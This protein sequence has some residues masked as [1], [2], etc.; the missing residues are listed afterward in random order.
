MILWLPGCFYKECWL[1][2]KDDIMATLVQFSV[3][4]LEICNS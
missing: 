2:I 3:V 1:I 4:I